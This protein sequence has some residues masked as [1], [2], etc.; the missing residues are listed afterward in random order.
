MNPY[1]DWFYR[2]LL[3]F[4]TNINEIKNKHIIFF[5]YKHF[6]INNLHIHVCLFCNRSLEIIKLTILCKYEHHFIF[7]I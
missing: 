4:I 6:N 3:P 1:P 2:S 7:T 5:A